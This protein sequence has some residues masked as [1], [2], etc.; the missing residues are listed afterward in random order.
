M[1]NKPFQVTRSELIP[2]PADP[3]SET[4]PFLS[5]LATA[6]IQHHSWA[7]YLYSVLSYPALHSVASNLLNHGSGDVCYSC[8]CMVSSQ[9]THQ[10]YGCILRMLCV[11][12]SWETSFYSQSVSYLIPFRGL[13]GSCFS[14]TWD[15]LNRICL[16]KSSL[17]YKGPPKENPR[18]RR[19]SLPSVSSPSLL[20]H[21][22]RN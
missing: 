21:L 9:S 22:I 7:P 20:K 19:D 13:L 14:Y 1:M 4:L 5:I 11:Q 12:L 18:T 3:T 15:N 10:P 17:P 2:N 16:S 6:F 8:P